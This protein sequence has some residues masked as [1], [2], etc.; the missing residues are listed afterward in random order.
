MITFLEGRLD[1]KQPTRVV[2]NVGGVG[3]E[4][5]IP[6]SSFDRLPAPGE[7]CRILTHLV[8][9]ED[10]HLLYG[11]TD[12]KERVMFLKLVGVNGVGPRIALATLSG[13][14]PRDLVNAILEGDVKRLTSVPG[15]GKKMAERLCVELKDKIDEADAL[16]ARSHI[17]GG[18]APD[19]KLQD[20]TL[21]LVGLGYKQ[22]DA[23]KRVEAV[24]ATKATAD[25]S[26]EELLRAA[27]G[28]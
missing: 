14:S 10:A 24:A 28:S 16:Q 17:P 20:A 19:S 5:S 15:I 7:T 26:V 9:R 4:L 13:L 3:Y 8:V 11:F 22:A 6:L 25:M 18:D 12:E 23:A 2:L 21:A 1:E 27:L